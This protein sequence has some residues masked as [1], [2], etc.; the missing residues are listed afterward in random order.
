MATFLL[1]AGILAIVFSAVKSRQLTA[2]IPPELREHT[3]GTGIVPSWISLINIL[4]W[5]TVLAGVV[6]FI[7]T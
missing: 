3:A 7:V 1:I 4:G 6:M 5:I 2:H